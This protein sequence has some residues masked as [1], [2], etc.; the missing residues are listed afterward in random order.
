MRSSIRK[1]IIFRNRGFGLLWTGQL[2]SSAGSWLLVVAVPVYVFHL[3]GSATDTGLA[4][5]AEVSPLLLVGPVAGVFADRWRRRRVMIV[6]DLLR[7]GSVSL[8]LLADSRRLLW[9]VLLAI[10]AESCGGAFFNPAY[11]GLLTRLVGR[12][13]DLELANAWSSA[14][15]G[16]VRLAG[17]PLGGAL[18]VAAGFRVPVAID[19]ASYLASALLITLVR[20]TEDPSSEDGAAENGG[21]GAQAGAERLANRPANRLAN[22][23]ALGAALGELAAEQ[24][25]GI[26]ALRGDRV[27]T[28]L[29]ASSALFLL[30]NGALTALVVPYVVADLGV[31]AA[32]V[33]ELFCAL[34]AGYLLSTYVGRRACASPRLRA[35]VV[36]LLATSVAAFAAFFNWHVFAPGIAFMVVIGVAGGAFLMLEQTLVQRRAPDE[37]IGRISSAYSTVVMAATLAG[38]LL[39]SVLVTWLGRAIALNLAIAVVAV[40]A[41]VAVRLPATVRSADALAA[42]ALRPTG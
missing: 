35:S 11:N 8:L 16:I 15:A 39:A 29:L 20:G 7:A 4:F 27:L 37:L 2:L 34:G 38:A 41:V 5:V 21:S 26:G 30:G 17:A 28:V 13:R 32:S 12:G 9:L 25:L 36:G 33:G 22:R 19:A 6:M 24:R 42:S 10:F 14:S 23:P 18:Y 1:M 31:R 3:T 40:G